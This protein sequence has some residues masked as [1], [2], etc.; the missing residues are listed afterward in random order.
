MTEH[1]LKPSGQASRGSE[2]GMAE[3]VLD[4]QALEVA[5]GDVKVVFGVSLHVNKGELVGRVGGNGSGKSNDTGL[6][7]Q[8]STPIT[9]KPDYRLVSV[10]LN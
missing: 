4:V 7:D 5:Y 6:H 10:C 8:K 9:Y 1:F 3:R 2:Q